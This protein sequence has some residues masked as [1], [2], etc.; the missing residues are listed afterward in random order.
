MSPKVSK[1]YKGL[2]ME[3]FI[4][5]WYAKSTKKNMEQYK[6]WARRVAEHA[7]E[8]S[9]VLDLAPGPGYLARE[10]AKLGNYQVVGLDISETFVEIAQTKGK[11][12][13]VEIE[14]RQGEAANMPFDHETFDFIVCTS[15]FKIFTEPVGVLSKM[16]RG[17]NTNEKS[18][19]IN[20]RR[21]AYQEVIDSHVKMQVRIE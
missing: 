8:G 7:A 10:L 18:L 5:S 20:L 14:F 11:E 16:Y 21:D 3:G 6:A 4:A 15:A 1:I 19:I 9:C 13:G 2:A 12:A 17:L